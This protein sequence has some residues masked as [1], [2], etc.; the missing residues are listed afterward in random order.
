MFISLCGIYFFISG[1]DFSFKWEVIYGVKF[2]KYLIKR[3]WMSFRFGFGFSF[4]VGY[5]VI[6]ERESR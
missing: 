6:A 4:V 5:G 1:L 3:N 2:E